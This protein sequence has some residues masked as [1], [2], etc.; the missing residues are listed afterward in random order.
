MMLEIAMGALTTLLGV[1]FGCMVLE[2]AMRALK[3]SMRSLNYEETGEQFQTPGPLAWEG[4]QVSVRIPPF[5]PGD[6]VR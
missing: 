3:H 2:L 1:A 5:A 4:E 6:H